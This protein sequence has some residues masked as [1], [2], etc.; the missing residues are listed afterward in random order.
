MLSVLGCLIGE[1]I[2]G[3]LSE[4]MDMRLVVVLVEVVV[5]ASAVLIM[6]GGRK[7]VAPIYNRE[8]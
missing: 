2:A 8:Q 5:F 3:V 1:G 4:L 6:G 7:S